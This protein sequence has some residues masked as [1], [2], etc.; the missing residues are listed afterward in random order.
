M[1]PAALVDRKP[2][3]RAHGSRPD[4][5]LD[6]LAVRRE[7]GRRAPGEHCEQAGGHEEVGVHDIR[8][9]P[10][11][12]R[13]DIPGERGVPE[14]PPRRS[15]TARASSCPR[16]SRPASS[17][18]TNVPRSGASGPGYI[19]ETRRMRTRRGATAE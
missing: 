1:I 11:C 7:H 12:G 8:A 19:W 14:R 15:T 10:P 9:K 6:V 2:R 3:G 18:A 5:V 17:S 4:R 13:H 16:A